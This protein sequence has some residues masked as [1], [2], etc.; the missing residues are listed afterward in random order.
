MSH[1]RARCRKSAKEYKCLWEF[2]IT[3]SIEM[4][5]RL[6][7]NRPRVNIKCVGSKRKTCIGHRPGAGTMMLQLGLLSRWQ[8]QPLQCLTW[9]F[10]PG[11]SPDLTQPRIRKAN[12]PYRHRGFPSTGLYL[13][14]C[15]VSCPLP[16]L[17]CSK[18]NCDIQAMFKILCACVIVCSCVCICV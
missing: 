11:F 5:V 12:I 18:I 4:A 10:M 2:P 17:I 7:P 9:N 14:H 13:L 8:L 15:K 16:L 1:K 3:G 6:F